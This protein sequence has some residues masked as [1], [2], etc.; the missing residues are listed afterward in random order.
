MAET[1][2]VKL[3]TRYAGPG[4]N[5]EPGAVVS[6]GLAEA[7]MLIA[8]GYA[9]IEGVRPV[10]VAMIGAPEKS[11]IERGAVASSTRNDKNLTPSPSPKGKGKK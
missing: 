5:F 8:G 2:L 9:V 7:Q 3:V 4:G 10:E 6:L 1:M 11:V